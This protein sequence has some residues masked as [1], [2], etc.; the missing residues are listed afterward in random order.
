MLKKL[1]SLKNRR[2]VAAKSCGTGGK[3]QKG[4]KWDETMV[5]LRKVLYLVMKFI[6]GNAN[7]HKTLQNEAYGYV[8]SA[9]KRKSARKTKK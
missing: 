9:E 8:E 4:V 1:L 2:C 3:A 5:L 6:G 7:K